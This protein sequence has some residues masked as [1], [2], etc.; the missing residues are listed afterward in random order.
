MPI[1]AA[2]AE[3][4]TVTSNGAREGTERA[5]WA[6]PSALED[7]LKS[8]S[9]QQGR[10]GL[11]AGFPGAVCKNKLAWPRHLKICQPQIFK[12]VIRGVWVSGLL[13]RKFEQL[14]QI[15]TIVAGLMTA[16]KRNLQT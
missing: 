10:L 15:Y 5:H 14:T 8:F 3:S 13:L 2:E 12:N 6:L 7:F 1:P 4:F 9:C 11:M 16:Q